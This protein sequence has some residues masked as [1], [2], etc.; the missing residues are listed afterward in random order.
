MV[1]QFGS[2]LWTINSRFKL[3][4]GATLLSHVTRDRDPN[5]LFRHIVK[6]PWKVMHFSSRYLAYC[7]AL[8]SPCVATGSAVKNLLMS[9]HMSLVTKTKTLCDNKCVLSHVP[10]DMDPLK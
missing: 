5:K 10:R 4:K 1:L 2:N 8:I 9:S 6:H 3:E 7:S